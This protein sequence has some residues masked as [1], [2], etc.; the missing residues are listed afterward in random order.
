MLKSPYF[1]FCY[2]F[3]YRSIL[4]KKWNQN[5]K[6]KKTGNVPTYKHN[7]EA[8]SHSHICHG[9]TIRITYSDGV[10]VA[11]VIRHAKRLRLAILSSVASPALQYFS[12]LFHERHDF[13]KK[14]IIGHKM[15][16]L[17]FST[18]SF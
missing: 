1:S 11:L 15:Y 3:C 13:R 9:K 8:R 18:T 5:L 4:A 10:F 2:A 6:Y 17:I 14:K 12:T 16:V 7:T